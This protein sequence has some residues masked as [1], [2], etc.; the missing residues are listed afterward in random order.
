MLRTLATSALLVTLSLAG[1][2]GE[3]E[4]GE[5][6]P[7][8]PEGGTTAPSDVN[9]TLT[10][11]NITTTTNT[12]TPVQVVWEIASDAA[13]PVMAN[14][15]EVRWG[16]T[17]ASEPTTGDYP[18]SASTLED[19]QV[20]GSF[21]ASFTHAVIETIYVRAYAVL[22]EKEFWSEEESVVVEFSKGPVRFV[23]VGGPPPAG[24]SYA[25]AFAPSSLTIKLYEGVQ[26]R[27][28]DAAS[29]PHTATSTASPAVFDTGSVAA[30]QNSKEIYFTKTGTFQYRCTIHM[31][32]QPATIIVQ[33]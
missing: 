2:F 4:E 25:A 27:N 8:P 26:W 19:V 22:G 13:E 18:M 9:L 29:A 15:T 32:M 5:P 6:S 23:Q 7:S 11:A 3:D 1:C 30:N 10:I 16:N 17:S 31:T 12:T 33:A 14:Q 20:P 24:S 21:N 28:R